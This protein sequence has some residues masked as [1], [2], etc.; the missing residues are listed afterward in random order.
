MGPS[1]FHKLLIGLE[2]FNRDSK[3]PNRDLYVLNVFHK[4]PS[5]V[6]PLT[7]NF[8][9]SASF[10]GHHSHWGLLFSRG[11]LVNISSVIMQLCMI[12]FLWLIGTLIIFFKA[13]EWINYLITNSSPPPLPSQLS[14]GSLFSNNWYQSGRSLK[15]KFNT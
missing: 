12:I 6:H 7:R 3:S 4:T 15:E 10:C 5:R 8:H 9:I 13:I 1:V 2:S 14:W 11:S